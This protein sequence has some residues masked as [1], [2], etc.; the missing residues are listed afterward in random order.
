[1]ILSFVWCHWFCRVYK[2]AW[3]VFHARGKCTRGNNCSFA[4]SAEELRQLP[5]LRKTKLC[6]AFLGGQCSNNNCSYAHGLQELRDF[7]GKKG[8]CRLYREGR[9]NEKTEFNLTL[10]YL[11]IPWPWAGLNKQSYT[12]VVMPIICTSI[13]ARSEQSHNLTCIFFFEP[14]Q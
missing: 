11:V 5:D 13:V 4:H 7:P 6:N 8:L 1:M 12:N 9:S 14:V 10:F 2:A 3:C